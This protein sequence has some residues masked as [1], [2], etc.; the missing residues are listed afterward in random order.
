MALDARKERGEYK[1]A[2]GDFVRATGCVTV[3][4]SGSVARSFTK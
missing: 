2:D 3:T 4:A 1:D